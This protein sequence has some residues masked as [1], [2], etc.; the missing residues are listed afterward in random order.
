MS[1]V[2]IATG[3]FSPDI[4]GPAS[5]AEILAPH[6][7]LGHQLTIITYSSVWTDPDDT[8][9]PYRV[10]RVWRKWPKLVRHLIYSLRVLWESRNAQ[11]LYALSAMNAG[12][13]M[14]LAGK[15][16]H[17][18][19]IVRI[20]GDYAWE[21]AMNK[22]MT[23]LLLDEFQ[24]AKKVFSLRM[25]HR[26]QS[27]IAKRASK[28]VVPS[29]Y[30]AGIVE[31][32]G[33]DLEKIVVIYNA[34]SVYDSGL[35]RQEARQAIGIPGLLIVSVGRLVPWK[36]FRMLIK[37]M[38]QILKEFQFARLVILGDGP[39]KQTLVSMVKHMKLENK[40]YLVGSKSKADLATYLAAADI[41]V[42]NT[43][44]EGFSHQLVEAMALG[45]P[46]VTT[47]VGGNKELVQ[48]GKNGFMVKYNDEF[49]LIEALRS[50][51]KSQELRDEFVA[52][53]RAT[54]KRFNQPEMIK[55][56]LKMLFGK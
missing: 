38:P 1:K 33:V 50:L 17:T 44:Y 20:A 31:G 30:L 46:V 22:G 25:L 12:I 26:I 11:V 36:G 16:F 5:Y 40:V 39:E 41:F 53:G 42:L 24:L 35:T 19:Y 27:T 8:K 14:W 9:R 37:I 55:N 34:Q 15:L 18:P 45:V 47:D 2:V 21:R 28:V 48:Q 52:E 43:G 51:L 23:T 49:N 13:A 4:G 32:W 6:I 10:I 56:N 29:K 7:A 54:A 3:I